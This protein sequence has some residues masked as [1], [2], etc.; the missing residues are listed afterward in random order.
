MYS[1]LT[2]LF[3]F[4]KTPE[5]DYVKLKVKRG[6]KPVIDPRYQNKTFAESKLIEAI[7]R[8]WE[9][10]PKKRIDAFGVLEILREAL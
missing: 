8:C 1:L 10:D 6:E 2:G 3:P 7:L 9:F 4:F 5:E